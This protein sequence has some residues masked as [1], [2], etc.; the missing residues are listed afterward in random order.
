[1]SVKIPGNVKAIGE[2]HAA[3][4][5]AN[6]EHGL[7]VRMLM[8][9]GAEDNTYGSVTRE[10]IDR[11]V[12]E[13][14]QFYPQSFDGIAADCMILDE[15]YQAGEISDSI[16][17]Y[18]DDMLGDAAEQ[19]HRDF[20][21][22]HEACERLDEQYGDTDYAKRVYTMLYGNETVDIKQPRISERRVERELE[23]EPEEGFEPIEI[24]EAEEQKDD[25]MFTTRGVRKSFDRSL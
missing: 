18:M 19:I 24:E 10:D 23:E 25:Y 21:D 6:L 13:E 7:R 1:M 15:A 20:V 17:D 11:W 4:S 22:V 14:S 16:Y 8:A 12:E 2:R 3:L 5:E 9:A